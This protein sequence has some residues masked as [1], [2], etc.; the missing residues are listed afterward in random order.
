[1]S[2]KTENSSGAP[3][4]TDAT[5]T[6][7]AMYICEFV[8]NGT[9]DSRCAAKLVKRLKKEADVISANGKVGKL[10]HRDL[11]KAFDAVD[12]AVRH[13]DANLLVAANA[14]LRATDEGKSAA[15]SQ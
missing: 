9:L 2:K 8:T 6:A 5:L 13:H 10:V 14:S 15:K 4:T 3:E 1:M 7:L 12:A 11:Q